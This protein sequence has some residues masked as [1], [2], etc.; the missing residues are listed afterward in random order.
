M[1]NRHI[2]Q[3]G[4]TLIELIV[5]LTIIAIL[6]IV[7]VPRLIETQRDAR[8]AKAQ[9]VQGVLRS[10]SALAH[11]RCLLDLSST[12]ASQTLINCKSNPPAVDMEGTMVAIQHRYPAASADGIDAAAQITGMGDGLIVSNA[13]SAIPTRIYDIAGG[14]APECRVTYQEATFNGGVYTAPVFSLVTT[15]C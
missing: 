5:V 11:G 8:I 4:F 1:K 3:G 6:A 7:A 9:A 15:G 13:G 10:A 2:A 12:A 14:T